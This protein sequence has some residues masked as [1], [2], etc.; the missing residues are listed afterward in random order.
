MPRWC[1]TDSDCPRGF[2]SNLR[3]QAPFLMRSERGRG[4]HVVNPLCLTVSGRSLGRTN[5]MRSMIAVSPVSFSVVVVS[6]RQPATLVSLVQA[7]REAAQIIQALGEVRTQLLDR[8]H[9]RLTDTYTSANEAFFEKLGNSFALRFF[10]RQFQS[11]ATPQIIEG[12]VRDLVRPA[13]EQATDLLR[14][15]RE[16]LDKTARAL[17]G[18]EALTADKLIV[19]PDGA[20]WLRG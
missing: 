18:R 20:L 14:Q 9:E 13:Q 12:C 10:G 15:R 4:V 1:R 6:C 19:L 16:T 11:Q 7:L 8:L 2:A 17:P 5:M 3:S